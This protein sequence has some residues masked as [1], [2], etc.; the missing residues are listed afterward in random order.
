MLK[1]QQRNTRS[2]LSCQHTSFQWHVIDMTEFLYIFYASVGNITSNR[3][4]RVSKKCHSMKYDIYNKVPVFVEASTEGGH[5]CRQRSVHVV[6]T[7]D[8]M[9]H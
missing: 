2:F 6:I 7:M 8:T 9:V 4:F 1:I 3:I 5:G